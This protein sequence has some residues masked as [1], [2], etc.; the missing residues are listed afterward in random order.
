MK[1][2]SVAL[3]LLCAG[4]ANFTPQASLVGEYWNGDGFWPR[5]LDLGADG[6]FIYDQMTD[7]M[8]MIDDEHFEFEGS[9]HLSGRW[10]FVPPDRIEMVTDGRPERISVFVRRSKKGEFVILEPDMFSDILSTWSDDG[11]LRYLKRQKKKPNQSLQRNAG[12]APSADEALQ[13]R[14]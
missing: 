12:T 5:S 6:S 1:F 3:G 10:T 2:W 11:S 4:C 13:P 8:R 14:G 7:T 9:W